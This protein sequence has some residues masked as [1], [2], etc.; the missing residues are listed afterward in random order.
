MRSAW[1]ALAA[2][3]VARLLVAAVT[4]L[5]PDEAYYWVW[6]RALAGGYPDH[7]PMVALW[8]RV[9]TFVA[10][11]GPLGVRLLAPFATALGTVLLFRAGDDFFPGRGAGLTA[12]LLLN[13]TLL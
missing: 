6:S 4:P 5:S 3:T 12:A 13:A 9:G 8:I 10:G 7:P 2:L 1:I 11:D